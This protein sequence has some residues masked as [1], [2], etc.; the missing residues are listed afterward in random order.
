VTAYGAYDLDRDRE[1]APAGPADPGAILGAVRE[2]IRQTLRTAWIDPALEATA[3]SIPFFTAAWSAVRPNVGKSFL[4][5]AKALRAEAVEAVRARLDA[6]DLRG[7]LAGELSAEEIRRIE[8][9]SRA[10]HLAA[11]KIQ[12]VVHAVYRAAR[13]E[14]VPGTGR[15]ESPVRRGVPEWQRWM[16]F[17]PAPEA[18]RGILE[19]C[20]SV[21][22][23]PV[24]PMSMRL[25]ARWPAALDSLW[26]VLKP[27]VATDAWK[28]PTGRL[29]RV[30]L[31]GISTLPHP[32]EVQWAALRARGFTEQDRSRLVDVL[33]SHD[34]AMAAQTLSAAF[35]WTAFGAPEIGVEG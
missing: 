30:V 25:I 31:A 5:L 14:R 28:A 16:S 27:Q 6:P 24:P 12:V 13:R 7:R 15:E 32:V 11:A 18:A 3:T 9:T 19:E 35:A 8:E 10:A 2:D 1:P 29:R 20:S 33:A 34:A 26:D 17:Q 22:G 21:F 23:S 4:L